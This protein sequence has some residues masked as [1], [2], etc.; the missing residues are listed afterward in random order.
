MEKSYWADI[1]IFQFGTPASIV[2]KVF[3]INNKLKVPKIVCTEFDDNFLCIH[4]SNNAYV[5]YGT[6][7]I[8]LKNGTYVWQDRKPRKGINKV[9]NIKENKQ[10]IDLMKEAMVNCDMITSTQDTLAKVFK[11]FNRHSFVLPNY[12]NPEVMPPA[13]PRDRSRTIICWQGGDSH[14]N[15]LRSIMPALKKIKNAF[16]NAVHFRFFGVTFYQMLEKELGGEVFPWVRPNNFYKLFAD[17]MADIGLIP[18]MDNEFNK[19]KSNIK[20]LEYSHYGMPSVVAN[21]SPYKEHISHN[22]TGLLYNNNK[23]LV[24]YLAMLIQDPIKRINLGAAAK[25]EVDT[26]WTIQENA[27]K[28]YDLYAHAL[29]AK[30][31][32]LGNEAY[33]DSDFKLD[34]SF[35]E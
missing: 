7:E 31:K 8:K 5:V 1:I 12:I 11:Q 9:F 2:C 4:P 15:D 20:W 26:N 23:E 14:Y 30:I 6:E 3:D 33:R 25:K 13:K 22:R 17:N 35:H 28:W 27:Y 24:D 16:G 32:H 19:S 10:R 34:I 29:A 21:V 18:L